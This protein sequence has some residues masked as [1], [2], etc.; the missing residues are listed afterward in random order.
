M[1]KNEEEMSKLVSFNIKPWTRTVIMA[2]CNSSL[3][4]EAYWR[5]AVPWRNIVQFRPLLAFSIKRQFHDQFQMHHWSGV[6][7]TMHW[8]ESC[9]ENNG[10]GF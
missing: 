4:M 1:Q 3:G 10:E 5:G 2:A 7:E 9:H 8:W 6:A